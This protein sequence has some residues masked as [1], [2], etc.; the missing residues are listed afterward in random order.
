MYFLEKVEGAG[1]RDPRGAGGASAHETSEASPGQGSPAKRRPLSQGFWGWMAVLWH[2]A[3]PTPSLS[4]AQDIP[5][6]SIIR[7]LTAVLVGCLNICMKIASLVIH[8]DGGSSRTVPSR[9]TAVPLLDH[10]APLAL[11][12]ALG[13]EPLSPGSLESSLLLSKQL[14]PPA[15][16]STLLHAWCVHMSERRF[17]APSR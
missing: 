7:P 16:A 4:R 10:M 12:P 5:P 1:G 2:R 17:K 15:E 6:L 13:N 9:E 11:H 3:Q 14:R 8:P